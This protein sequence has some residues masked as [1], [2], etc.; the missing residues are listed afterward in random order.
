MLPGGAPG[1][2]AVIATPLSYMNESGGPVAGLMRFYKIPVERLIV[3]HDELDIPFGSV[4][5]KRGGGEGGHNGLRSISKSLGTRD[6]LRVRGGSSQTPGRREPP[7]LFLPDF[8][9][10]KRV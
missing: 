8:S 3:V 7:A 5:L 1:P 6:Y 9:P 10:T 4:R 2:R